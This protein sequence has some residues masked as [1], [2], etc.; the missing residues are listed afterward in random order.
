MLTQGLRE[1]LDQRAH[2]LYA[3]NTTMKAVDI[4]DISEAAAKFEKSIPLGVEPFGIVLAPDLGKL[5]TGNSDSTLA[6]ID[7]APTSS[8]T[9]RLLAKVPTGGKTRADLGRLTVHRC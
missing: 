5:F 3:S 6:I 4:Y 7:V 1:L 9:D 2:R 8:R